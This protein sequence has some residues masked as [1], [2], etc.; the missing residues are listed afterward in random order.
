MKKKIGIILTGIA[1]ISAIIG[2]E[3]LIR[4]NLKAKAI[5]EDLEETVE[6]GEE[7][8]DPTEEIA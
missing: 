1:A 6:E 4:G 5:E 8:I 3:E 2:T 7:L